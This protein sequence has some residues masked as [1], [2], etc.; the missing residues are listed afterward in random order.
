MNDL[1]N[2]FGLRISVSPES[3]EAA[4]NFCFEQGC[5][6][7]E[8]QESDILAY[9]PGESPSENLKKSFQ[10]YI[11]NLRKNGLIIGDPDWIAV[12]DEDW[13]RTW[14]QFFKPVH[15]TRHVVVKPPWEKWM[16]SKEI[17]ID[18]MPKMAFGTGTHETTQLCAELLEENMQPSATVLD[19]GSGSGILSILAVKLGAKKAL[20]LDIDPVCIDNGKE[21]ALLN[22]VEDRIDFHL[23]PLNTLSPRQFGIILANINLLILEKL[24]PILSSYRYKDSIIILSGVL[25]ENT[26][27]LRTCCGDSDLDWVEIRQ[28]NEWI[29]VLT[30]PS[31]D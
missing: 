7:L 5:S 31:P 28:K 23:G 18:I 15:L 21:N 26:E 27:R 30:Q 3:R 6:G 22:R 11:E 20:G 13:G 12:P 10:T 14:R 17:V 29:G 4:A 24:L 25:A 9:F 19:V 8:E 16:S 1:K 2:W